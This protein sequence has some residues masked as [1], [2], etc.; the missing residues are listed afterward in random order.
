MLS[1]AACHSSSPFLTSTLPLLA[2]TELKTSPSHALQPDLLIIR[3]KS[4]FTRVATCKY[5]DN[6]PGPGRQV[7]I[8]GSSSSLPGCMKQMY[9]HMWI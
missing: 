9:V 4:A 6:G 8:Y 3:T 1:V 2:S 5:T 7:A